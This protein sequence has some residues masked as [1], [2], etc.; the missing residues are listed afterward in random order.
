[1]TVRRPK[2]PLFTIRTALLLLYSLLVAIGTAALLLVAGRNSAE[3]ALGA[4]AAFAGALKLLN[5]LVD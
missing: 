3:A 5:E 1:M 4:V 2:R